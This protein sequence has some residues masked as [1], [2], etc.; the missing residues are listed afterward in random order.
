M[1]R[2]LF[3]NHT[4]DVFGAET[5]LLSIFKSINAD[6]MEY[7]HVLEP[8]YK[9]T[10]SDFRRAAMECGVKNIISLPY[11]NL[12]GGIIRN[13]FVLIYNIYAATRTALYVKKHNI[14]TIY[15]NTSVTCLGCIVALLTR[16]KH[17]WH[18]HE[19]LTEYYISKSTLP[20]L[21]KLFSYKRNKFVFI[22]RIHEKEWKN[23]F[24]NISDSC[25]IYN[26]IK[27]I[28]P[29]LKKPSEKIVF[30]YIGSLAVRKNVISLVK[31]YNAYTIDHIGS[32]H[33]LI[34]DNDG[35]AKKDIHDL[36]EA[37]KNL[38]NHI[39]FTKERNIGNLFKNIDILIL[40]SYSETWGMVATEAMSAGI[41]V[42]ATKNSGLTDIFE[43]NKEVVYI[44]PYNISDIT[45]ALISIS[46]EKTRTDIANNAISK[47]N[48]FDFNSNFATHIQ[49]LLE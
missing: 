32:S 28:P 11:K 35:D 48:A 13:F 34:T 5:V 16:K 45:N 43:N 30:G 24:H 49:A 1:S 22:S 44:D 26:P 31:A 18:I 19:P 29:F 8:R 37:D 33:L 4:N 38:K 9:K 21:K 36:V 40:P 46:D 25:I 41:P 3:I 17:I 23:R 6:R 15:S 12:G 10:N 7:V 2:T 42:I 27:Q 39:I 47:L 14:D 20:V